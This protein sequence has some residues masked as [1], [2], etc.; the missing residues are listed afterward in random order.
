MG[1]ASSK[2]VVCRNCHAP[3][4][5]VRRR[6]SMEGGESHHRVSLT[7]STIGSLRLDSPNHI[8]P[9]RIN[10]RCKPMGLVEAKSWSQM[11]NEKIPKVVPKT[12][13]HTPPGEPETINAWELM[14][15]LEDVSPLKPP[16]R[17]VRSFSFDV[18]SSPSP[19]PAPI[20]YDLPTP[21]MKS[22]CCVSVKPASMQ[23]DH[24]ES[25]ST[26]IDTSMVCEIDPEMVSAFK[27]TLDNKP[28][29]ITHKDLETLEEDVE[30]ASEYS[31]LC[32]NKVV[33]YFT[34][35]R[36]VR[37]TYEDCCHVR[38]LLKGLGVK[39]DERD[40][41]MHS[42]FKDE[43]RELLGDG[44]NATCLPRVFVGKKCIGGVDEIRRMHEDGQL[45]KAVESCERAQLGGGC[46]GG[47]GFAC[48]T[49]GDIRFVPCETCS[50]SCK[51]YCEA[52]SDEDKY[53]Q[54]GDYGFQRCPDCNENGLTRC[55]FC[56]D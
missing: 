47:N 13:T 52:D 33:V 41:S 17:F 45:E 31:K 25:K 55:L 35:L 56:C 6:H 2:E 9:H 11:I 54:E 39:I 4:S 5:P 46:D 12:P 7:S 32:K 24:D 36:G 16:G 23:N 8:H 3:C 28:L 20:P 15:G 43:L 53:D 48:E 30:V 38:V 18:H 37:K 40:L 1:C 21:R 50:G 44:Y 42:G 22:G 34:S 49:C 14:E 19:N 26:S 29:A 10:T 27:E 51:I